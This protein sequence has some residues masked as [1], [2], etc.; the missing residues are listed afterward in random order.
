MR[1]MGQGLGPGFT[2]VTTRR[3]VIFS[4]DGLEL[5]LTPFVW[6]STDSLVS[7]PISQC[8]CRGL[9][10]V[11]PA[12]YVSIFFAHGRSSSADCYSPKVCQKLVMD[13]GESEPEV[14][15]Q[16]LKLAKNI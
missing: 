14:C 8:Q 4:V 11:P 2:T 9:Q 6:A 3:S 7:S 10:Y 12:K 5:V 16:S 15:G 1:M 13:S